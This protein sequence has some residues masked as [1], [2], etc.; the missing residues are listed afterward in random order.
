MKKDAHKTIKPNRRAGLIVFG[1]IIA[2]VAIAFFV[3]IIIGDGTEKFS[4]KMKA[5]AKAE[6]RSVPKLKDGVQRATSGTILYHVEDVYKTPAEVAKSWCGS[7]YNPDEDY[8]SVVISE[9][10]IFGIKTNEF[11]RHDA[12]IL[13]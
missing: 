3:P 2:L 7:I 12:C 5:A 6:L 11:T 8:Y 13:L 1:S 4:G 10:T 9:R